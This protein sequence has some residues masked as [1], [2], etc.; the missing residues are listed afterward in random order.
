MTA[1]APTTASR[2]P[3]KFVEKASPSAATPA[4]MSQIGERRTHKV[5][6]IAQ[7]HDIITGRA[8]H[9]S[10][11]PA[12]S[13]ETASPH[14]MR[15]FVSSGFASIHFVTFPVIDM[16]A[17]SSCS[18]TGP[19]CH[20][21]AAKRSPIPRSRRTFIPSAVSVTL[22]LNPLYVHSRTRVIAS[23]RS[24]SVPVEMS[25]FVA[26]S[27]TNPVFVS[28]AKFPFRAC[29]IQFVSCLKSSVVAFA[30]FSAM[31]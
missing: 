23:A 10:P 26:S 1:H 28:D 12:T 7:N 21:I 13:A 4:T 3:M 9:K 24:I 27:R 31:I 19:T 5:V 6:A 11:I 29:A 18:N 15:F 20:D 17:L 16:I 8:S 25:F 2:N 30:P 22:L 14:N